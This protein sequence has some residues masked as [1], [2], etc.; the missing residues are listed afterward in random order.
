MPR[1]HRD[2]ISTT[3]LD[4]VKARHSGAWQRLV[5]LYG[6]VVYRWC[7]QS[8]LKAEDAADVVQEVFLSV[9]S[10]VAEF[11]RARPRDSFTAWLSTITRNKIR[12]CFRRQ[13]DR[14]QARGGTQAQQRLLEVSESD[15]SSALEEWPRAADIVDAERILTQRT[16]ELVRLE[17]EPHTWEAWYKTAIE[18]RPAADVAADLGMSLHAVYKAKSRILLRLR[19]ELAS[20]HGE[21]TNPSPLPPEEGSHQSPLPPGEG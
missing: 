15:P 5:D 10:H 19:Q 18:G 1:P 17:F 21:T 14:P 11:R 4:L 8:G 20:L 7:R 13:A 9:A 2:S 12:D 3:L 6:G 16:V